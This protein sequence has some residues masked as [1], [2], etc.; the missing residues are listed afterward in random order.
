[1]THDSGISRAAL[2]M[3]MRLRLLVMGATVH[4]GKWLHAT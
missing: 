2:D 4:P 3:A 1:M